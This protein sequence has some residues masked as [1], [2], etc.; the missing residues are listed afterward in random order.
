MG[1]ASRDR[2]VLFFS[3]DPDSSVAIEWL[4]ERHDA[5]IVTLTLDLGEGLDL[6]E[7][8]DRAKRIG[9]VR[10]HVLDVHE[11]FTDA[12]PIM[13]KHLVE[14]AHI[15]GAKTIAHPSS[16]VDGEEIESVAHALDPAI[17]VLAIP[18]PPS[19]RRPRRS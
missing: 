13:A 10:A 17:A 12:E 3:G 19:R 6:R 2:I 15:E 1:Q 11:S 8:R 5:E 16:G 4:A 18:S 14:V 7:V 9:A